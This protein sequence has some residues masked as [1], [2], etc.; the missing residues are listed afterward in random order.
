MF[1]LCLL[2]AGFYHKWMLNFVNESEVAQLC[3][4]LCNTMDCILP[5]SSS[6]GIFQARALEW[7]ASGFSRT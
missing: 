7:V 6:H 3:P 5:G 4:T 2:H 1:F